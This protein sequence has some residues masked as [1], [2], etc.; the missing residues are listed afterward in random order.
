VASFL[1]NSSLPHCAAPGLDPLTPPQLATSS[2]SARDVRLRIARLA[3]ANFEGAKAAG[4]LVVVDH[5][6]SNERY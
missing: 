1:S 2:E 6:A 3:S 4:E 5:H